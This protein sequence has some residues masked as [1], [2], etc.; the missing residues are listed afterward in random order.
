MRV[1]IAPSHPAGTVLAPSSKSIGH[2]MLICA[3]LAEGESRIEGLT[4]SQDILATIDCLRALGAQIEIAGDA[5]RVVGADLFTAGETILPCRESGS[6]LRFFLPLCLLSS[7]EKT[8]VGAP[9]LLSRPQQ[10]YR[11]LCAERGIAFSQSETAITVCGRLRGGCYRLDGSISSQFF[12]GLL[13]ALPLLDGDSEIVIENGLQSRSYLELTRT[14]LADSGV[15][16][17]WAGEERLIIPGRQRYRPICGRVEGDYSGAAF[18]SALDR[19]FG[20]GISVEGLRADS[21]QGDSVYPAL[22]DRI[23]AHDPTPIDLTDC[24]DLGPICFA[25]AAELGGGRFVGTERLKWKESDRI[26]AMARELRAMGGELREEN[27]CVTVENRPLHAPDRAL[28][29]HNDHRIVMSLSV[30][31]ARYG[32]T[33]EGAEAVSKSMPD[34]FERLRALGVNVISEEAHAGSS[35]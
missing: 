34:F 23:A 18:F 16:T 8:L 7:S 21:G 27:G 13:F 31:L 32:G 3:G 20:S 12:S 2:R 14:A 9:S 17:H 24:P 19:V 11:T 26:A 6:T 22:F 1:T 30:L 33:I 35:Q 29:G 5:A 10:I 28:C 25:L 15:K 4:F